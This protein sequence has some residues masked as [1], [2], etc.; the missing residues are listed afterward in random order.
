MSKTDYLILGFSIFF[1]WIIPSLF[2]I[3]YGFKLNKKMTWK[4]IATGLFTPWGVGSMIKIYLDYIGKIT[5][6]WSCFLKPQGLVVFVPAS[7]CWGIPFLLIGLLSRQLIQKSFLGIQ[8]ERGKFYLLI[9]IL[10]GAFI[11]AGRIF[12]SVFWIFDAMAI[13]APIWIFYI[14]DLLIGLLMGWLIGRKID[15]IN[16]K[17]KKIKNYDD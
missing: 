11:G 3:G 4:I 14:K 5:L 12:V 1:I 2:F 10:V 9:G 17:H 6:P 7:I 8:S 15:S 13:F 16:T